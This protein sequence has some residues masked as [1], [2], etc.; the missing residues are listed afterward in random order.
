MGVLSLLL[1]D[2]QLCKD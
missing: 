1:V 2:D